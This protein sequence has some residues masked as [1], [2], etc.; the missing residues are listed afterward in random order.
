MNQATSSQATQGQISQGQQAQNQGSLKQQSQRQPQ[1]QPSNPQH[2]QIESHR[3]QREQV[4]NQQPQSQ[5][6]R[7]EKSETYT[8]GNFFY[9]LLQVETNKRK[10]NRESDFE[11]GKGPFNIRYEYWT[12]AGIPEDY[13]TR[14]L[15]L[16]KS[17]ECIRTWMNRHCKPEWSK[18]MSLEDC[19]T[20]VRKYRGGPKGNTVDPDNEYWIEF[21]EYLNPD[22]TC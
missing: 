5:P 17:K 11:E 20:C 19:E 21:K 4:K 10:G 18:T 9:A 15:E 22:K 14:I 12:E 13:K 16:E 3:P 8:P 1:Q 2:E 6:P 7:K